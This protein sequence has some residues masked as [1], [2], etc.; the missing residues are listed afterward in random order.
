MIVPQ[1]CTNSIKKVSYRLP[2]FSYSLYG[3]EYLY[4]SRI[5]RHISISYILKD[6]LGFESKSC[7]TEHPSPNLLRLPP[8]LYLFSRSQYTQNDV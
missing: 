6:S 8:S 3:M 1:L 2:F 7:L 5:F 4:N